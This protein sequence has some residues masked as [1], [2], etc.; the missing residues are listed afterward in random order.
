MAHVRKKQALKTKQNN[1]KQGNVETGDQAV[2]GIQHK[3]G[4][5]RRPILHEVL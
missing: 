5:M 2:H 4:E 3:G 1:R